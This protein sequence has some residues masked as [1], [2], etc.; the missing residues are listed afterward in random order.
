MKPYLLVILSLALFFIGCNSDQAE[1]KAIK[2]ETFRVNFSLPFESS[3]LDETNFQLFDNTGNLCSAILDTLTKT[4]GNIEFELPRGKYSYSIRTVFNEKITKHLT[5]K[6]DSTFSFYSN[7]YSQVDVITQEELSKSKVIKLVIIYDY[8][9]DKKDA[10]EI[11]KIENQYWLKSE[12]KADGEWANVS[13]IDSTV[14][15]DNFSEFESIIIGNREVENF[16]E[17]LKYDY[18]NS[19]KV[20]LKVD[21]SFIEI[22]GV[23]NSILERSFKQLIQNLRKT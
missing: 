23:K 9:D 16:D 20:Y 2:R 14:L 17:F 22:I 11:E 8:F 7:C 15:F 19:S 6:S 13:M 18:M 10:I 5:I 21:T 4:G 3:N 12:R 1:Q